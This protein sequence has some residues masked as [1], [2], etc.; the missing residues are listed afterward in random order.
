MSHTGTKP[1]RC[2]ICG[3][4]YASHDS[5]KQHLKKHEEDWTDYSEP[6]QCTECKKWFDKSWRLK[7]HGQILISGKFVSMDPRLQIIPKLIEN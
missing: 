6:H 3:N 2:V 5:V 1:F 7:D 4:S